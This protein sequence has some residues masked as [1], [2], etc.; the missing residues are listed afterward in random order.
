MAMDQVPASDPR[1]IAVEGLF[2]EL[3][4]VVGQ[5]YA[6]YDAFQEALAPVMAAA[7][8]MTGP[9]D[10]SGAG[11]FVPPSALHVIA[12][13]KLPGGLVGLEYVG[14]GVHVSYARKKAAPT[15]PVVEEP[16]ADP[17]DA[18]FAGSCRMS[19][20]AAAPGN[21][22]F[23][24]EVCANYGDCCEDLAEFCPGA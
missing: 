7:R 14:H 13:G 15:E 8:Q 23:C 12:Q 17:I 2:D 16:P 6:S 4:S 1:R 5:P 19:C 3:I 10:T 24:D 20:G 21:S 11:L 22:C 9:R 18:P